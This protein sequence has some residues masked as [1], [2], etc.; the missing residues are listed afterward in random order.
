MRAIRTRKCRYQHACPLC[1]RPVLVGQS[2]AL[3]YGRGWSHTGCLILGRAAVPG[4]AG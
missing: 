1:P 4:G 3:I 2:E